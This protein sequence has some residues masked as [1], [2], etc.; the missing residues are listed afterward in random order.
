MVGA[1]E[2]QLPPDR[3]IDTELPLVGGGLG[4]DGDLAVEV[5]ETL[6]EVV[7]ALGGREVIEEDQPDRAGEDQAVGL[8]QVLAQQFVEMRLPG[9]CDRVDPARRAA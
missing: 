3:E 5:G 4:V 7:Q 9:G 1:E 6:A 8:G 2:G